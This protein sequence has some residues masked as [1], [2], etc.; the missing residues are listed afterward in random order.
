LQS[1]IIPYL[2]FNQIHP[3]LILV[4]VFA[5]TFLHN[6]RQILFWALIGGAILDVLTNT[7]F[8]LFSLGLLI[9]CAAAS[10]WQDKS[11]GNPF[12]VPILL[13]LPYTLLFNLIVLLG[14]QVL[15]YSIA[16]ENILTRILFPASFVNFITM[17]ILFPLLV[18]LERWT[19]KDSLKI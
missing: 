11:F 10:F 5:W 12:L 17:I 18:R 1:T 8:G 19:Q 4:L 9:T 3:N 7:P 15:G 14:M 13:I 2:N 16:W 6:S